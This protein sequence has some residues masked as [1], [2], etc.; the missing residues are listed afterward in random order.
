MSLLAMLLFFL[1]VSFAV[2]YLMAGPSHRYSRGSG[3]VKVSKAVTAERSRED[4]VARLRDQY[5]SDE[6]SLHEFQTKV[7]QALRRKTPLPPPD[8]GIRSR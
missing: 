7:D 1:V 5:A 2:G 3:Q 8:P 4:Q 6:I